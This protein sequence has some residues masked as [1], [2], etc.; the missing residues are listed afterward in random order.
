MA[1]TNAN[2]ES[3]TVAFREILSFAQ[4]IFVVIGRNWNGFLW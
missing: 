2:S 1:W 4:G 3:S